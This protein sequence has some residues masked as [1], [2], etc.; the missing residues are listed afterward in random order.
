MTEDELRALVDKLNSMPD[1]SDEELEKFNRW[2][3][4]L[5]ELLDAAEKDIGV[6]G[7]MTLTSKAMVTLAVLT[8][9]P[10]DRL[11]V[12]VALSYFAI[13]ESLEGDDNLTS[14]QFVH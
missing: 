11:Q 8:G 14:S 7:I 4:A 1:I 13:K 2:G 10:L 9:V 3:S 5:T 6:S 12:G